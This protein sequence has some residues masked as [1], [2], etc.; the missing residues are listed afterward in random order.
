MPISEVRVCT[1]AGLNKNRIEN[2]EHGAGLCK[3]NY[4]F[5]EHKHTRS[6]EVNEALRHS[7]ILVFSVHEATRG[8]Y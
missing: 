6:H 3:R 1:V 4:V 8:Y 2:Q 7:T 5:Q